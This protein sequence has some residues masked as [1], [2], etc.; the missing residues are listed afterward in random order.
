MF[1]SGIARSFFSVKAQ[2]TDGAQQVLDLTPY[3]EG[4]RPQARRSL[5]LS[6]AMVAALAGIGFADQARAQASDAC[7]PID[8]NG[9][10]VCDPAGNPFAGGIAYDA[11]PVDAA[12]PASDLLD[13]DVLLRS[14][15]AISLPPSSTASA[16]IDLS[17]ARH[18]SVIL[19]AEADTGV[20]TQ[21]RGQAGLR[22]VTENGSIAAFAPDIVTTGDYSGGIALESQNGSSQLSARSVT[23]AGERA[24]AIDARATNGGDVAITVDGPVATSGFASVGIAA[25]AT[26]SA[27]SGSS[28]VSVSAGDISTYGYYS[29][30][31]VARGRDVSVA[32]D[33]AVSTNGYNAYGAYVRATDG[34]AAVSIEGSVTTNGLRADAVNVRSVDGDVAIALN[35][36]I[37][38]YGDAAVGISAASEN[39]DVVIT[40][41]GSVLT[42]GWVSTGVSARSSY[43]DV[44][45][46]LASVVT[47][48]TGLVGAF[49]VSAS[50]SYGDATVRI[51]TASTMANFVRTVSVSS[52]TGNATLESTGAIYAGGDHSVA[53]D[54]T[55]GGTATL[56]VQD[57]LTT[58]YG[59]TAVQAEG[60]AVAMAIG[61]TVASE[62]GANPYVCSYA[63]RATGTRAYIPGPVEIGP[64]G[65]YVY[66]GAFADTGGDINIVNNGTVAA[67]GGNVGGIYATSPGAVTITGDGDVV[68]QGDGVSGIAVSA[69]EDAIVG[70][71]SVAAYGAGTTGVRVNSGGSAAVTLGNLLGQGEGA[72]G[73]ALTTVGDAVAT[74]DQFA[75]EGSSTNGIQVTA[76]GDALVAAANGAVIGDY[77]TAVYASAAGD[78]GV[79]VGNITGAGYYVDGV[80]VVSGGNAYVAAGTVAVAGDYAGGISV[81]AA[82]DVVIGAES[83]SAYGTGAV[84][85]S[86]E[87]P[88]SI[89]VAVGRAE[90]SG[91]YSTAIDL[92]AGGDVT[93]GAEEVVANGAGSIGI[94]SFGAGAASVAVGSATATGV[95]SAAVDISAQTGVE[96]SAGLVTAQGAYATG[97]GVATYGAADLSIGVALASGEGATAIDVMASQGAAIEAG[98]IGA[99]GARATGLFAYSEGVVAVDAGSVV[100][101]GDDSNGLYIGA[102]AANIAIDSVAASGMQANGVYLRSYGPAAV[103][104]G[105]AEATGTRS[106]GLNLR[107]RTGPITL[108]AES[109][110]AQGLEATGAVLGSNGAVDAQLLAANVA[111]DAGI[112]VQVRAG[113]DAA[114]VLG[115]L[116]VTGTQAMGVDLIA[117]GDAQISI[118]SV[119]VAGDYAVGIAASANGAIT[120]SVGDM[121]VSGY[122]ARGIVLTG[123]G[124][125]DLTVAGTVTGSADQPRGPDVPVGAG[126]RVQD[127]ARAIVTA[128]SYDTT[129]ITHSGTISTTGTLEG[130]IAARGYNGAAITSTGTISTTGAGATGVYAGANSGVVAISTGT[131]STSG[132][133]ARAVHAR[134]YGVALA[135][136]ER[137][138]TSGDRSIGLLV[139]AGSA[140]IGAAETISTSG[141]NAHAM[142]VHSYGSADAA[143]G[144]I[145]VSGPGALGIDVASYGVG[146]VSAIAGSVT[147]ADGR[148]VGAFAAN[149]AASITIDTLVQASSQ[150]DAGLYAYGSSGATIAF[151]S[152]TS[153]GGEGSVGAVRARTSDGAIL[154]AGHDVSA[155]GAQRDA[156][157]ATS[158]S[159]DIG[160]LIDGM[161]T[162]DGAGASGIF[163]RTGGG[164]TIDVGGVTT[165][166]T[167]YGSIEA[168]GASVSLN[169]ASVVATGDNGSDGALAAVAL[170]GGAVD[171]TVGTVSA[172]GLDRDGIAIAASDTGALTVQAGGSV[173]ATHDAVTFATGGGA[174]LDNQ[175]TIVGGTGAAVRATGAGV[176]IDN[177]GLIDGA[178]I[179]SDSADSIANSGTLILTSG[180]ALGDG[181]DRLANSGLVQIAG[182]VDFGAGSDSFVN[183]GVVRLTASE[184]S[185][186]VTRMMTGLE[187]F[188]SSGL[189]DMRNAMVGDVLSLSGDFA[190]SGA[191]TVGLDIAYSGDSVTADR[192]VIGGAA[193]GSTVVTLDISGT[194]ELGRT[195]ALVQAGAG[196]S[197][198]A[199]TLAADQ[200]ESGL[201][202]RG[203]VFD[204]ASNSFALAVAPSVAAYRMLNVGEGAQS[205]WLESAD[206]VAAHLAANRQGGVAGSGFW[207]AAIGGVAKR[208]EAAVFDAFGF[209]QAADIGY[210]QDMFGTQFGFDLGQGDVGFGITGGYASSV[211]RFAGAADRVTFDAWNIGAYAHVAKDGFF[212][213]ALVKYDFY[214]VEARLTGSDGPAKTD[215]SGLGAR[216]EVGF[217]LGSDALRIEPVASLS[218]QRIA[219]DP[220]DLPLAID[221]DDLKG[222]RASAGLRLRTQQQM[223]GNA[224]LNLYAQGDY[225]Q[226]FDGNATVTFSTATTGVAFTDDRMGAYGKG[227]FGL[228]ITQGRVTGFIEGEGRFSGDYRAGGGKVGL[229]IAF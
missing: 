179:L 74:V 85:V 138:T 150:A 66:T 93:I 39:G 210:T 24:R 131:V 69:G 121:D 2:E 80:G 127:P 91:T 61:G 70:M 104:I 160:I 26:P 157:L 195:Q 199:F 94:V 21:E 72:T 101:S 33:G 119:S 100:I 228:S 49:G 12:D 164:I 96:L 213:N 190:G 136:S 148:G 184:A 75:M 129:S 159:G 3:L 125:I 46:D 73:I 192:L 18:A 187:S 55:A 207:M 23:T 163:A 68:V 37:A 166:S 206:S 8:D 78:V 32:L 99:E 118:G 145:M 62:G 5:V 186:P 31:L 60:N 115:D 154:I 180:T 114:L 67:S 224:L 20:L 198:S 14:G 226:P 182:D 38:T 40:G 202:Q 35:G 168:E 222:G 98:D 110:T 189:I 22:V 15:V 144:T 218:W 126:G 95:D 77:A 108:A 19:Y 41:Q 117:G 63:V 54:V 156:V 52:G 140:A 204:S 214:D 25:I 175:G 139:E 81:Q 158:V 34:D 6:T 217:S 89:T 112:A 120:A 1:G 229:R 196:T 134:S 103:A 152:V 58:G 209:D 90:A 82:G 143:A 162:A 227:R 220:L 7:G 71:G 13:L 51:D 29:D 76:G 170:R 176:A 173:S 219:L 225:V 149:G 45:V 188:A 165:N 107:S 142:V 65:E 205:L 191:S 57:V 211:M 161:V 128:L 16:G 36:T 43:G 197:A 146:D 178:L 221:F 27:T 137:I 201:F 30:A 123:N 79:S 155:S 151:N 87:T 122:G 50:S 97:V 47:R 132:D 181:D 130:G 10:V 64:D 106:I 59:A 212:A 56:A 48:A 169:A 102:G 28:S 177:Q 111:G 193:T 215:G 133:D 17:A 9:Q 208:D 53:V 174:A 183:I 105:T 135:S 167:Q 141:A 185:A 109:V 113:T 124:P 153:N 172:T 216:G 11:R 4:R 200:V 86:A 84:G 88:G 116:S 194:P 83:V 171:A 147:V 92:L 42:E 44:L 223:G 203:L